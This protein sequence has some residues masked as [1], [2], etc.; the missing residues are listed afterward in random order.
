MILRSIA[1]ERA[2][3]A[4]SN[5]VHRMLTADAEAELSGFEKWQILV[6]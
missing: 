3:A 4:L 2:R 5:P 1:F 6:E